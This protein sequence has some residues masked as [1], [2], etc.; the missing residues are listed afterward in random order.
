[1]SGSAAG[2]R[3]RWIIHLND[4]LAGVPLWKTRRG[5]LAIARRGVL[6]LPVA[7]AALGQRGVEVVGRIAERDTAF[8]IWGAAV[9]F[10]LN[11]LVNCHQVV[12]GGAEHL[13]GLVQ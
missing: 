3:C 4:S 9:G 2:C 13:D 12:A 10:A 8:T 6:S 11:A 7:G 1:M 5:Y